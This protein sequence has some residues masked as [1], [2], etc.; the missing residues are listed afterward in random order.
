VMTHRHPHGVRSEQNEIRINLDEAR[1]QIGDALQLQSLNEQNPVRYAVS[2]LGY[3]K[4][5]SVMVSV[6]EIDG[7]LLIIRDGQ[8]FV[9]RAFS[10]RNVYAFTATVIK[11]TSAPF[12]HLHLSYPAD[13]RGLTVRKGARAKV[14]LIVAI[15]RDDDACFSAAGVMEN[16]SISGCLVAS[17][18]VLGK[19]GETVEVK[20]KLVVAGIESVLS[21]PAVVRA[22]N[23]DYDP[24]VTGENRYG[25]EFGTVSPQDMIVL[26]AFVYQRLLEQAT[27]GG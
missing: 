5:K 22:V 11:S 24:S 6:P 14:N 10:G 27:V 21:I 2:L 16:I 3:A 17:R 8:T 23:V 26:S 12:P 19:K 7:R 9:V 20:F 15:G 1:L 13:V 25:I 18:T 4:G